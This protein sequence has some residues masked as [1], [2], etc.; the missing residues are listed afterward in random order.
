MTNRDEDD[1]ELRE[2]KA[3]TSHGHLS[4]SSTFTKFCL[5]HGAETVAKP[6]CYNRIC[7]RSFRLFARVTKLHRRKAGLTSWIAL[8]C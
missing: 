8:N 3:L 1:E 5:N 6:L 4:S 2:N 7:R